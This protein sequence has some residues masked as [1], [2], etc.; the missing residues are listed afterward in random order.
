MLRGGVGWAGV[1]VACGCDFQYYN[2]GSS[3]QGTLKVSFIAKLI[4]K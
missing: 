1:F 4:I 3:L 2:E